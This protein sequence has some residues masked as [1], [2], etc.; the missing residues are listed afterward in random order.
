MPARNISR[1][2]IGIKAGFRM[3]IVIRI[4]GSQSEGDH[5]QW[6]QIAKNRLRFWVEP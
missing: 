5:D 4:R 3:S 2:K 6:L 1:D